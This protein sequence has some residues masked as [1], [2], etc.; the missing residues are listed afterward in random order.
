MSCI[1]GAVV[2]S[3]GNA[4][5]EPSSFIDPL[6]DGSA[7]QRDLQ[8]LQQLKVNTIRAY[9]VNASLNHDACM[10]AFSGAG[11]YTMYGI[12]LFL[13]FLG[14][15]ALVISI[16]LTL[17]LN[18]SIDRASPSWSTNLLDLY[19]STIDSFSK[20]D[21]VLAYNV[22]NEVV[23][24]ANQTDVAAYVKA[25]ARDT[26]AYLQSKG[27]SA[28]VGYAAIDGDATWRDPLANYLSCDAT[29]SGSG[30]TAIDLYGLNN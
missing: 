16:D 12:C 25:A 22:G 28:L 2:A 15:N 26:K 13:S 20:Y 17:P 19:I 3:A 18:G 21:N 7:C 24:A 11:I 14:T 23:I 6:S 29:S 4:F 10:Q 5:G 9:S 27:S 8:Y 30:S 1:S